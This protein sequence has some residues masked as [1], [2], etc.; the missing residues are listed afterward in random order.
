MFRWTV[1]LNEQFPGELI[2]RQETNRRS[3]A[4]TS[5]QG[6]IVAES[7]CMIFRREP[8]VTS[9]L[10]DLVGVNCSDALVCPGLAQQTNN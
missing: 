9:R 10:V 7:V 4:M 2:D 3:P 6:S 1:D 8:S 5:G